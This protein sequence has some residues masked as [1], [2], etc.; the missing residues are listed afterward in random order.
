[1]NFNNLTVEGYTAFILAIIFSIATIALVIYFFRNKNANKFV[2]VLA[3]LVAPILTVFC[4]IYLIMNVCAF[5]LENSLYIAL[6]S[7]AGYAILA[8]AISFSIN[9]ILNKKEKSAPKKVKQEKP[10]E[11]K[12]EI[13][14]KEAPIVV[15]PLLIANEQEKVET[16]EEP[17]AESEETTSD[18][19]VEQPLEVEE[20]EETQ[21]VENVEN[22]EE[23]VETTPETTEELETEI[24]S[25][26][27]VEVENDETAETVETPVEATEEID[28]VEEVAEATEENTEPVSDETVEQPIE[29]K[30]ESET[31]ETSNLVEEIIV[32]DKEESTEDGE[33]EVKVV[34]PDEN[35]EFQ[36]TLVE[37]NDDEE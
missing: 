10:V 27:N 9:A 6:G 30:E 15:A 32:E 20:T 36:D 35:V 22:I 21:I 31:E 26:E 14:E 29:I 25:E 17:V 34:S 8:L 16:V 24:K 4:W 23:S 19:T 1:M 37:F 2:T 7:A 12:T 5:S 28:V 3:T 33:D 13:V 18:E 11:A